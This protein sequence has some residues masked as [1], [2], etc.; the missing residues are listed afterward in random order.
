MD[1]FPFKAI[2]KGINQTNIA[3]ITSKINIQIENYKNLAIEK[4]STNSTKK[5]G[6]KDVSRESIIDYLIFLMIIRSCLTINNRSENES[7]LRDEILNQD[8]NFDFSSLI[9]D[10]NQ[11]EDPAGLS[12][13][14][15]KEIL[16]VINEKE[17]WIANYFKNIE[18]ISKKIKINGQINMG[19]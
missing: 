10:T 2:V 1:A 19:D 6:K 9:R 17:K 12:Y 15:S 16:S 11:I 5:K 3:E 13:F 7:E 4:M 14:L 18:S 8:N